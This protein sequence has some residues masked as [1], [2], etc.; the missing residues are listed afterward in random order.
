MRFR[1][2]WPAGRWPGRR[3]IKSINPQTLVTKLPNPKPKPLTPNPKPRLILR[4][5]KFPNPKPETPDHK[6]QTPNP[7]PQTQDPKPQ[8][9]HA[10]VRLHRPPLPCALLHVVEDP[11]AN[12]RPKLRCVA[13]DNSGYDPRQ[14]PFLSVSG[15]G[16]TCWWLSLNYG[17]M[18]DLLALFLLLPCLVF[19][20]FLHLFKSISLQ[21][22][23]GNRILYAGGKGS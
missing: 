17:A 8:T 7:K 3:S 19:S 22:R 10:G 21:V 16:P 20:C 11:R 6:H 2:H 4:S 15:L 9:L 14:P 1:S 5:L 18:L 13:R 23:R 12:A